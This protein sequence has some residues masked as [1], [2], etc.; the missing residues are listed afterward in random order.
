MTHFEES[1][2]ASKISSISNSRFESS[3]KVPGGFAFA[4][5][6]EGK[7][8]DLEVLFKKCSWLQSLKEIHRVLKDDGVFTMVDIKGTSNPFE[9]K[10]HYGAYAAT[11]Y[12]ISLLHCLPISSNSP[13][14][15]CFF[16]LEI[17]IRILDS[18][19]FGR[20]HYF[21]EAVLQM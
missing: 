2:E 4:M 9:D 14:S 19:T 7:N 8:A 3:R 5:I 12:G 21:G 11:Q 18:V 13:G 17:S 1:R 10:K 6:R 20:S 16:R 15:L